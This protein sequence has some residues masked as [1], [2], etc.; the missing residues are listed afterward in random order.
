MIDKLQRLKAMHRHGLIVNAIYELYVRAYTKSYWRKII[1]LLTFRVNRKVS[2]KQV[3]LLGCYNSGTTIL[4]EILKA[5]PEIC[6]MPREGEKYTSVFSNMEKDGWIRMAYKNRHLAPSSLSAVKA[7]QQLDKDWG[8]WCESSEKTFLEKS[9][10]HAYRIEFLKEIYP[11]AKFVMIVRDGYCSTEGILR[12]AEPRGQARKDTGGIYPAKLC[13]QQW[14]DINSRLLAAAEMPSSKLVKFEDFVSNPYEIM[15]DIFDFIGVDV[16]SLGVSGR[17]LVVGGINFEINNPNP[18]SRERF[19]E[20]YINEFND[21]A[22][23]TLTG[24][25]Y[26]LMEPVYE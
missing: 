8:Y 21:V 24:F 4:R 13:A 18:S 20:S 6:G 3:F 9:I 23:S 25:G 5:H 14:V 7:R 12:R 26:D 17:E 1:P 16:N 15:K 10:A 19:P 22:A 2:D 11:S